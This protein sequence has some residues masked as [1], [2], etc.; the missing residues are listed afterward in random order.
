MYPEE[1]DAAAIAELTNG[2][3]PAAPPKT[4]AS[5]R[6]RKE[7]CVGRFVDDS[8]LPF[9]PKSKSGLKRRVTQGGGELAAA[10]AFDSA[11]RKLRRDRAHGTSSTDAGRTTHWFRLNFPTKAEEVIA[12][13]NGMPIKGI[14]AARPVEGIRAIEQGLITLPALD[15]GED[16]TVSSDASDASGTDATASSDA[17]DKEMDSGG[18]GILSIENIMSLSAEN[19]LS[20]ATTTA[21]AEIDDA[22]AAAEFGW[23]G[24]PAVS[25]ERDDP[26]EDV[27]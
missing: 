8:V 16:A 19:I 11:C 20:L 26:D 2:R 12:V 5:G 4:P 22:E 17:C 14:R 1:D 3:K 15:T 24:L 6:V 27:V 10:E 13:T 9:V 21:A 23:M 7:I 25:Q 18:G